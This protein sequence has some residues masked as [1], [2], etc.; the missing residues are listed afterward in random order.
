MG[1]MAAPCPEPVYYCA[2]GVAMPAFEPCKEIE[3][4][5]NI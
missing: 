4:Q 5:K 3:G 1:L 2:T